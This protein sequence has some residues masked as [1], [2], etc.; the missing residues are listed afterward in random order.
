MKN[1]KQNRIAGQLGAIGGAGHFYWSD[2]SLTRGKGFRDAF[3]E[4]Q[5]RKLLNFLAVGAKHINLKVILNSLVQVLCFK[6][7]WAECWNIEEAE[8]IMAFGNGKDEY[9][10]TWVDLSFQDKRIFKIFN[11]KF[12]ILFRL[13][14]VHS[15]SP[16]DRRIQWR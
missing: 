9:G 15:C 5:I 2:R 12:I 10:E 1:S 7:L 8:W 3:G 16:G 4:P 14:S 6:F 13:H 11:Q